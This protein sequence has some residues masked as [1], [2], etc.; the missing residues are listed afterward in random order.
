MIGNRP[1]SKS[2][3]LK[4]QPRIFRAPYESLKIVPW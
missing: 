4:S 1:A 3:P 2:W